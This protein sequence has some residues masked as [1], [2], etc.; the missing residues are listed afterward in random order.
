LKKNSS[1]D[2]KTYSLIK[3]LLQIQKLEPKNFTPIDDKYLKLLIN[4]E[5]NFE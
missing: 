5:I 1:Y 3:K 2:K 4:K